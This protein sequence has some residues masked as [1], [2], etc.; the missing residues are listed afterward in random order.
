MHDIWGL[1]ASSRVLLADL[2]G[3]NPN[4]FYELGLAHAAHKPVLL[5]TQ[6]LDDV[7][8]DLQS[9]RI[10]TYDVEHPSWGKVLIENIKYGL[11]ETLEAPERSVLPTFLLE[12]EANEDAKVSPEEARIIRLEQQVDSMQSELRSTRSRS[13]R[14]PS[15]EP[16][17]AQSLIMSYIEEGAPRGMIIERLAEFGVPVQWIEDELDKRMSRKKRPTGQRKLM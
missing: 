10:I 7:P 6:T 13:R 14:K 17:E 9:L 2:T 1:V 11:E 15:I 4:V 3:K 5:L 8:F 16:D 12:Q